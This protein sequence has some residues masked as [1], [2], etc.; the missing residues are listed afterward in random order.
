MTLAG[1]NRNTTQHNDRP[2]VK[3]GGGGGGGG[4]SGQWAVGSGHAALTSPALIFNHRGLTSGNLGTTYKT[5]IR[6]LEY[7]YVVYVDTYPHHQ[8]FLLIMSAA[9]LPTA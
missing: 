6:Y 7:L 4:V 8:R 9:Y 2:A 3:I 5:R 1:S